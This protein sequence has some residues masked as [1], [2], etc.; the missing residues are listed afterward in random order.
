[1]NIFEVI[2]KATESYTPAIQSL[3]DYLISITQEQEF[4]F[5]NHVFKF[6]PQI[7]WDYVLTIEEK[8]TQQ[9]IDFSQF[10]EQ[11]PVVI[12]KGIVTKQVHNTDPHNIMQELLQMLDEPAQDIVDV[13]DAD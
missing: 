1:M 13:Q 10:N 9:G 2:L 7:E 6:N 5:G 3:K 11:E 4:C 8:D 12:K